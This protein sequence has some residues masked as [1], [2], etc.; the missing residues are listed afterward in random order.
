MI[1]KLKFDDRTEF[2]QAKSHLHLLQS[3]ESEYDGFQDMEEL[4]EIS[5]EEA[6]KIMLKNTDYDES[7]PDDMEEISLYDSVVGDDFVLV[8]STDWV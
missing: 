2:A 6:K 8:G 3:Y 7:D 1:F 5:E 4:E